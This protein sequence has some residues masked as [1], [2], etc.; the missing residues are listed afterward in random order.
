MK[1]DNALVIT[2]EHLDYLKKVAENYDSMEMLNE[3]KFRSIFDAWRGFLSKE[4]YVIPEDE[5]DFFDWFFY[6]KNNTQAFTNEAFKEMTDMLTPEIFK[7]FSDYKK[8]KYGFKKADISRPQRTF[9]SCFKT[10]DGMDALLSAAVMSGLI[11]KNKDGEKHLWIEEG[12]K[13]HRLC[14]FWFAAKHAGLIKDN[15]KN[16][17]ATV[18]AIVY[19]FGIHWSKDTIDRCDVHNFEYKKLKK[20][21]DQALK[22][23]KT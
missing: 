19:F 17:E 12:S 9:R 4:G 23:K 15:L 10:Q 14:A 18:S 13:S 1:K 8:L 2:A 7:E 16:A 21:L 6:E 3:Q 22:N 11:L 5:D 20:M